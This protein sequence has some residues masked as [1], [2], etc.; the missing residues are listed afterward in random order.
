VSLEC[1]Q[2]GPH[3]LRCFSIPPD[4]PEWLHQFIAIKK[5]VSINHMNRSLHKS[6]RTPSRASHLEHLHK[7]LNGPERSSDDFGRY[8]T[9]YSFEK[10]YARLN[11]CVPG[12]NVSFISLVSGISADDIATGRTDRSP[13]E[14]VSKDSESFLEDVD[15]YLNDKK[16][17]DFELRGVDAK[18][19]V[20][21]SDENEKRLW[22]WLQLSLQAL[23]KRGADLLTYRLSPST[24]KA[25]AGMAQLAD[26]MEIMMLLEKA[27]S[28][29]SAF[30]KLSM[31]KHINQV[32]LK[33]KKK[34]EV[35]PNHLCEATDRRANCV[36]VELDQPEDA[37]TD[38]IG[39][40]MISDAFQ[41]DTSLFR[42]WMMLVLQ[43]TR[44]IREL[45]PTGRL[46]KILER[47]EIKFSQISPDH[48]SAVATSPFAPLDAVIANIQDHSSLMEELR[49]KPDV[50]K[51]VVLASAPKSQRHANFADFTFLEHGHTVTFRDTVH[52]ESFIACQGQ[53]KVSGYSRH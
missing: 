3:Q 32:L 51:E 29:S 15:Y 52:C 50:I 37:S 40:E 25:S 48:K 47:R 9:F 21:S 31:N 26:V 11:S 38:D 44:A 30:W 22:T 27:V 1:A 8:I 16:H 18:K 53:A 41:L 33:A 7:Y 14:A 2:S 24:S 39:D 5:C 12:T 42:E 10:I 17:F 4:I 6:T 19:R 20:S 35:C 34:L 13:P 43:W 49:G 28:R 46:A 36:N 23:H 45:K